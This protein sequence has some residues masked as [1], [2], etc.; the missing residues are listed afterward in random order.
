MG[1]YQMLF[2]FVVQW[3]KKKDAHLSNENGLGRGLLYHQR[4]SLLGK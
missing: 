4:Q 1:F 2:S 3:F